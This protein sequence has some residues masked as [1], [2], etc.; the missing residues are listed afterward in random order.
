[1]LPKKSPAFRLLDSLAPKK[2]NC[3]R[4]MSKYLWSL[5]IAASLTMIATDSFAERTLRVSFE[6]TGDPQIAVWL[7]TASGEFVDTLMI[8][9]L[10]GTFGLGNRPGRGDFGGGYLWPYG[11][12]EMVLPIW[13][14]RRNVDYDRI[15]MQDCKESWLG[16]HELTSSTEPFYCRPMTPSE[17]AVDTVSCPTI[18]FRTDK[19][20]PLR[21]VNKQASDYCRDITSTLVETSKYPPRNDISTADPSRDWSGVLELSQYNDLDAVSQATPMADRLYSIT[22]Q[23][24]EAL[25]D[26]DYV[27]WVEVNQQYD[28][29][30][31]H[32]YEFYVDPALR[33]YGLPPVGQPSVVWQ[34]PVNVNNEKQ[35]L[36]SNSYAGYGSVDGTDGDVRPPDDTISTDR[37]GSGA[38]RLNMVEDNELPYQ[39]KVD[40]ITDSEDPSFVCPVP[41]AVTSI[42]ADSSYFDY[43]DVSFLSTATSAEQVSRYEVRY[44]TQPILTEDDFQSAVPGPALLSN[45]ANESVSFRISQLQPDTEYFVAVRSFNSCQK[46]SELVTASISTD[47]REFATVDACFIATAAYGHLEDDSVKVLRK[48]RDEQ[49]MTNAPGRKFVELYYEISPPIADFIRENET[50]RTMTR[51][52]LI[53]FVEAARILE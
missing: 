47:V 53:P 28:S 21:L 15:V 20:I 26:G 44:S 42:E 19:G 25:A 27:V 3:P 11:R 51:W 32:S 39:V 30:S 33:D 41:P 14:H 36:Y 29:N 1:M 17:M 34:V 35:A 49:L 4:S 48:F 7:E 38:R 24:P 5:A 16:W 8:T 10:T 40:Y 6:P 52:S 37:K 50:L 9:R 2:T 13:A 23:L 22:Y 31:H 43:V 12:R 45:A 46:S 18:N